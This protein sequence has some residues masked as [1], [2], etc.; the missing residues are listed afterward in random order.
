MLTRHDQE[1]LDYMNNHYNGK[2]AYN[3]ARKIVCY[4]FKLT[5]KNKCSIIEEIKKMEERGK[6]NERIC[7]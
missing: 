4:K 7:Y 2:C 3:I 1:L 5:K 6:Q